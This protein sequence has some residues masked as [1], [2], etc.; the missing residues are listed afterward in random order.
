MKKILAITTILLLI[1]GGIF[2]GTS[3][4][5]NYNSGKQAF[6]NGK[7]EE[8]KN[9]F[10]ELNDYKDSEDLILECDYREIEKLIEKKEFDK[11][12]VIIKKYEENERFREI[13][14]EKD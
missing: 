11:A 13:K 1:V 7:Y 6:E 12:D 14:K 10:Q 5:R 2:I 8:A 9:I 4:L 3:D